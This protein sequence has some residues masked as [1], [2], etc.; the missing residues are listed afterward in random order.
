MQKA[1]QAV[2]EE[3]GVH[4]AAHKAVT[5]SPEGVILGAIIKGLGQ[6]ATPGASKITRFLVLLW[7]VLRRKR[8]SPRSIAALL[9]QACFMAQFR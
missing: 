1:M 5:M 9:G 6:E 8:P 2:Y 3:W 4:R 7:H